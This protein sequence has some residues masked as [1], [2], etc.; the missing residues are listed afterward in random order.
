MGDERAQIQA[1]TRKILAEAKNVPLTGLQ[2]QQAT[3]LASQQ[4]LESKGRTALFDADTVLRGGQ[5]TMLGLQYPRA[6]NEADA[7]QS[8]WMQNV[9]PYLP[10]MLK[11]TNSAAAAAHIAR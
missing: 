2:I 5:F 3:L 1:A 10:D 11:S 6:L 7:Q 8:W 4:I 9:S